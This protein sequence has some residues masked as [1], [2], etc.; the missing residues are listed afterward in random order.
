M[1]KNETILTAPEILDVSEAFLKFRLMPGN[2]LKTI[3]D[4]YSLM[5]SPCIE[6][7]SLLNEM[8]FTTDVF[9][10]IIRQQFKL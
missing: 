7:D 9:E 5:T 8:K 1:E 4:F 6:R 2:E 10:N 3:N